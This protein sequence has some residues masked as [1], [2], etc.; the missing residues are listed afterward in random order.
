M[1]YSEL[2]AIKKLTQN[3]LKI[4]M[5]WIKIPGEIRI[6]PAPDILIINKD[7]PFTYRKVRH[8]KHIGIKLWGAI[9][10]LCNEHDYK[11]GWA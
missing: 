11:L 2:S 9:D 4:E 10:Y 3:G 7:N 6:E 5:E 1:K 8:Y